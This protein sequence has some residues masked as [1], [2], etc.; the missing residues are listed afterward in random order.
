AVLASRADE[1]DQAA[2][3]AAAQRDALAAPADA[4][5]EAL[6]P[7]LRSLE[8]A[9]APPPLPPRDTDAA[10][11]RTVPT[12]AERLLRPL[13]DLRLRA[14]APRYDLAIGPFALSR[15]KTPPLSVAEGRPQVFEATTATSARGL[16]DLD[17]KT[18]AAAGQATRLLTHAERGAGP[19]APAATAAGSAVAFSAELARLF[20]ADGASAASSATTATPA[21]TRLAL[22]LLDRP[23]PDA[24]QRPDGHPLRYEQAL[25]IAS[26]LRA[27]AADAAQA[28]QVYERLRLLAP[29]ALDPWA[30]P[31]TATG[32]AA[33]AEA[34]TRA[35]FTARALPGADAGSGSGSGAGAR[36][37]PAVARL[38]N[39]AQRALAATSGG[40][41][42]LMDLQGLALP[43]VGDPGREAAQLALERHKL[44][45]RAEEALIALGLPVGGSQSTTDVRLAIEAHA[46]R[47]ELLDPT[48]LGTGNA[49]RRPGGP[50][51]PEHPAT[52]AAQAF[53]HAT[54]NLRNA[55]GQAEVRGD[56]K[57]AYVALRNGFTE[58]GQGSDFHLMAKRLRKFVTYIDLACKTPEGEAPG[59]FDRARWPA[60]ALRRLAGKDKSPL[61]TLLKSGPVG[62]ALK[63]KTPAGELDTDKDMKALQRAFDGAT[64]AE[65][66]DMLRQMV[67]AVA[68]DGL[69]SYSDARRHGV[70]VSAGLGGLAVANVGGASLGISPMVDASVDRTRTAMLKATILDTGILYLGSEKKLSGAVGAG[71]RAGADAGPFANVSAQAMAR[72][73]GSHLVSKGLMIR[74]R[75]AGLEHQGLSEAQTAN[76]RATDWKR[77]NELVV[78][79]IFQIADQPKAARPANGGAMWARMVEKVGDYRDISFGWNE[80]KATSVDVSAS[81]D[82]TAAFKLAPGVGISATAGIGVKQTLLDRKTARDAAGAARGVQAESGSRAA[83]RVGANASLGHPAVPL[84]GGRNLGLF[85]RHR[86]GVETELVLQSRNGLVRIATEDGKVRPELCARNREFGVR[87]D[88]IRVMNTQRDR[89]AAHLGTL[90]PDGAPRGGERQFD[91][92]MRQLV[93]L[94]TGPARIY[95]E[96][97]C[98]TTEAADAINACMDRLAILQRP[99]PPDTPRDPGAAEQAERLQR[100]IAAQVDAPSSWRPI[101]LVVIQPMQVAHIGRSGLEGGVSTLADGSGV[102]DRLMGGGKLSIGARSQTA[103]N[104]QVLLALDAAPQPERSP[105]LGLAMPQVSGAAAMPGDMAELA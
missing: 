14:G 8:E 60:R 55:P 1:A 6:R 49:R 39:A 81:L 4:A 16:K 45:L 27:V 71:V 67:G 79:S 68:A 92:F 65:R 21:V 73:G 59:R 38:A 50:H 9:L 10:P 20:H 99:L 52:L 26:V 66:R 43:P 70:G 80:A 62:T 19:P 48:R 94:P 53:L 40:F 57:P 41:Q 11:P 86:V 88:F 3:A 30:V 96:R 72:L 25:L 58:S 61:S 63:V 102:T 51:E 91:D 82:A 24:A 32:P 101:G 87:D 77:M 64:P 75:K 89:W 7:S 69:G 85:G 17:G 34:A 104:G 93:N 37:S 22:T 100:V 105:A 74:T 31:A 5:M 35:E 23:S 97:Q 44:G 13:Q 18:R 36:A 29:S 42:A 83:V 98:L 76:L 78:N 46:Q 103:S 33:T 54:E 47:A 28:E 84:P 2:R 56:F 12:L 15:S 95:L 90:A